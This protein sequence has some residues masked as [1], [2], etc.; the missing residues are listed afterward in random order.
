MNIFCASELQHINICCW[1]CYAIFIVSSALTICVILLFS[2]NY[3]GC[4]RK[5][6]QKN[7]TV[8]VPLIILCIV[9]LAIITVYLSVLGVTLNKNIWILRGN[10]S[11]QLGFE[12]CHCI[13]TLD[14][15][16]NVDHET[17]QTWKYKIMLL[18]FVGWEHLETPQWTSF[19]L[20]RLSWMNRSEENWMNRK[21]KKG[22]C[23]T[24]TVIMIF[25][26]CLVVPTWKESF[27]FMYPVHDTHNHM[28]RHDT[29]SHA[30]W[31]KSFWQ[32]KK[33]ETFGWQN[34]KMSELL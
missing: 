5:F 33:D 3:I 32:S 20:G 22:T 21:T 24:V 7:D 18:T 12:W 30:V 31:L 34:R 28:E 15:S 16:H 8:N 10:T 27:L 19:S 2:I 26:G 17:I 14:H 29:H 13:I 6:D 25:V 11:S 23:W 4:S 9:L 1:H